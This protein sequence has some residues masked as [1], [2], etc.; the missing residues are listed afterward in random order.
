MEWNVSSGMTGDISFRIGMNDRYDN[1]NGKWAIFTGLAQSIT[2]PLRCLI[3]RKI[4]HRKF[5]G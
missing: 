1:I 3:L 2:S 4:R 5:N